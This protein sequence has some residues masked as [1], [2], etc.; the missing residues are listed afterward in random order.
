MTLVVFETFSRVAPLG[1]RFWDVAAQAPVVDGLVVTARTPQKRVLPMVANSK[2]VYILQNVPGLRAFETGDGSIAFWNN[3]P[4]PQPYQLEARDTQRRFHPFKFEAG[5]PTRGIFAWD[6]PLSPPLAPA[7]VPS[8]YVPAYSTTSRPLPGGM[9]AVRADLYDPDADVPAAWAT[10]EVLL[11][12][13][14]LGRGIADMRGCVVVVF[15][16]PELVDTTPGSSPLDFGMPLEEQRWS[17]SLRAAYGPLD[18]VPSVPDLCAVLSQPE[19]DLWR[20]W[21]SPA[22][23]EPFTGVDLLYGREAIATSFDSTDEPVSRLYVTPV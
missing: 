8:G 17:L 1:V 16:Y 21:N 14:V 13:A 15:P 9:I 20:V 6:C 10:L 2:G 11:D 22:D 23:R 18:P 5:V 7:G 3:A 19:A 4:V 12:G